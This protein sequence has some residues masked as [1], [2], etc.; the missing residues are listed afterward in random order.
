MFCINCGEKLVDGSKFCPKCGT[1]LG[2]A[3]SKGNVSSGKDGNKVSAAALSFYKKGVE[4]NKQKDFVNAI[5]AYEKALKQ[6]PNF[7]EAYRDR[8]IAFCDIEEYD[9]AIKDF[10][11]AIDI[12]SDDASLFYLR[13]SCYYSRYDEDEDYDEQAIM[14]FTAAI[15]I[16]KNFIDAYLMRA[17]IYEEQGEY[18]SAIEDHSSVINIKPDNCDYYNERG[19]VYALNK[20][21]EKALGD[22]NKTLKIDSKNT[23]ALFYRGRVFAHMKK[24]KDAEKDLNKAIEINPENTTALSVH[25]VVSFYLKRP[26]KAKKDYDRILSINPIYPINNLRFYGNIQA[27][28]Y[29]EAITEFYN[30]GNKTVYG[31]FGDGDKKGES[32][33]ILSMYSDCSIHFNKFDKHRSHFAF[34]LLSDAEKYINKTLKNENYKNTDENDFSDFGSSPLL[35]VMGINK[36]YTMKMYE[37]KEPLYY[38]IFDANE[39]KVLGNI[40]EDGE[41]NW[42]EMSDVKY[43]DYEFNSPL[44]QLE[45]YLKLTVNFN[46]DNLYLLAYFDKYSSEGYK[47]Y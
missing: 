16:D 35:E 38:F 34:I 27:Y 45:T 14:D 5:L 17:K 32:E 10:D 36:V 6:E 12:N 15:E 43:I 18:N 46:Y 24:Y 29:K 40:Y 21:L 3:G 20:E 11:R 22:F 25:A 23:T 19:R 9:K 7:I 33:Q 47:G 42:G 26:S 41:L 31:I 28:A 8:A 37:S 44:V 1:K 30:A 39:K 2:E 13:G 4:Y